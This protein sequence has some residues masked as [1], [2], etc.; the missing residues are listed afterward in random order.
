LVKNWTG[1]KDQ[2][3]KDDRR[4]IGRIFFAEVGCPCLQKTKKLDGRFQ[5]LEKSASKLALMLFLAALI[6][7]C[8]AAGRPADGTHRASRR[9]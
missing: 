1:N 8:P 4:A 9:V 6:L 2:I 3:D 7:A 5:V